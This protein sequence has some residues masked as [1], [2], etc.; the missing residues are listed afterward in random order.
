MTGRDWRARAC[1]GL[2]GFGMTGGGAGV[3]LSR[4]RREGA[5]GV[6]G[7]LCRAGGGV[8]SGGTGAL[9]EYAWVV[10]MF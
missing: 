8:V 7:W 2:R 1:V 3:G 9:V 6:G 10:A 4:G 5:G